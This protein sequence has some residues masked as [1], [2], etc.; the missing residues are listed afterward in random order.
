MSVISDYQ[1]FLDD[2]GTDT[3]LHKLC[4]EDDYIVSAESFWGIGMIY[5]VRARAKKSNRSLRVRVIKVGD[6]SYR[7]GHSA[8]ELQAI[9]V[10]HSLPPY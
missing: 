7:Y 3:E 9:A 1:K 8:E 5:R 2:G 4:I 6:R 10:L